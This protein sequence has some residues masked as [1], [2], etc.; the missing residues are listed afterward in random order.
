MRD[1]VGI[2]LAPARLPQATAARLPLSA[3]FGGLV[4]LGV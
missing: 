1:P 3:R 4:G 2:L